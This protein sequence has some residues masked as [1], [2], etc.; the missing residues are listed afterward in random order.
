MLRMGRF[1]LVGSVLLAV[2]ACGEK[3]TDVRTRSRPISFAGTNAYFLSGTGSLYAP[4]GGSVPAS[5]LQIDIHESA[6][7]CGPSPGVTPP[8]QSLLTVALAGPP[9][10]PVTPGH[11]PI[12]VPPSLDHAQGAYFHQDSAG[13]ILVQVISG[14]LDLTSSGAT[15]D[16]S[17]DV[18]LQGG[19]R[20]SGDFTASPC[21]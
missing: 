10:R 11:Y 6:D 17:V 4:D 21:T 8:T 7:G 13:S 16:G 5:Y 1:L 18:T 2:A 12:A 19:T 3:K 14:E 15:A 9:D 20:V